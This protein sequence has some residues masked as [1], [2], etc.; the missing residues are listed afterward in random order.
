M[1]STRGLRKTTAN[2][3]RSGYVYCTNQDVDRVIHTGELYFGLSSVDAAESLVEALR[4]V[5][6]DP[7]WG[8]KPAEHVACEGLVVELPLADE[9]RPASAGVRSRAGP[10]GEL[11]PLR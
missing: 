4:S 1:D 10:A 5:G 7:T 6:L 8:G 11:L 2:D 3:S 9:F